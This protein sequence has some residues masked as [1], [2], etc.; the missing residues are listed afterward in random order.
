MGAHIFQKSERH[1]KILGARRVTWT[2][3]HTED[4]LMSGATAHNPVTVEI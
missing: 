4:A 2:K 1:L 3:F